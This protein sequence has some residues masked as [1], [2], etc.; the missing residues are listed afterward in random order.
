M[1][2]AATPLWR[3]AT[4]ELFLLTP[5][6][7]TEA[8][9]GWLRDPEVACYLESRFAEHDLASTRAFVADA[10]A[11]ELQLMLGI[12]STALGRHVGNIKLGPIDRHHRTAEVGIMIGDRAAWG[13]GIATE[14]ISMAAAISAA[15]LG[16][17]RLT[18][19]CYR[20]NAGSQRAFERAGFTVE[21]VRPGHFL[22]DGQPEDL[23]LM[24]RR[25]DGDGVAPSS[26]APL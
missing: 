8:Y 25:L 18:A 16:L 12:H 22:L 21:A 26:A 13:R 7:V 17:R 20:S 1:H 4:A 15:E 2:R 19:G 3:S 24:G 9:V 11:S 6:H 23:V 10:L 14:A 5:E